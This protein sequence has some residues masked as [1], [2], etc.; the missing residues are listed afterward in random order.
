MP[1]YRRS[2]AKGGIF[3]FTLVT[4]KRSPVFNDLNNIKIFR[5]IYKEVR[6]E[7]PFEEIACVILHD[8]IHS[9]WQL[10]VNDCDYSKRWG[11]IK[12]RYTKYL[13][14]KGYVEAVWQKRFWEH[15][16]RDSNDLNIHLDYLHYNP[17]KHGYVQ[18]VIDWPYSTFKR[19]VKE[20]CY[21]NDWGCDVIINDKYKY[22][23]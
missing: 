4:H 14:R 9:I 18:N 7:L 17:V 6:N 2:Y 20:N 21:P 16:I 19:Y 13:R 5:K 10:P 8:H 23:E 22:G 15:Q 1:N 3:F 11:V 12:S